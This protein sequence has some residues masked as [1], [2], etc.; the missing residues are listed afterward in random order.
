MT[1]GNPV[2]L[3]LPTDYPQCGVMDF[4]CKNKQCIPS[5]Y[6]CDGDDDCQDKSDEQFCE[7]ICANTSSGSPVSPLCVNNCLNITNAVSVDQRNLL[8][9]VDLYLMWQ[10][11]G[12]NELTSSG[13]GPSL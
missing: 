13:F 5:L 2:H 12:H 6:V 4:K 7:Q 9:T 3:M 1:D 11:R 8:H 10:E